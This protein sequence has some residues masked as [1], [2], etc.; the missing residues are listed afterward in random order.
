MR[1]LTDRQTDDFTDGPMGIMVR[2]ESL[3]H[4]EQVLTVILGDKKI[5][6][7][8]EHKGGSGNIHRPGEH[9]EG[10][11]HLIFA[12]RGGHALPTPLGASGLTVVARGWLEGVDY[13]VVP[14]PY[15]GGDGSSNPAWLI[16]TGCFID[17][18]FGYQHGYDIVITPCMNYYGK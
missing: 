14:N 18:D 13:M 3:K 1:G 2:G 8:I 9:T 11:T 4:L 5:G 15:S 16:R 10:F 17:Q 6:H 12:H 7:W